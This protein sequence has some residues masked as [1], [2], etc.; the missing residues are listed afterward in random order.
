ML[1]CVPVKTKINFFINAFAARTKTL[2]LKFSSVIWQSPFLLSAEFTKT[3]AG[4]WAIVFAN[5]SRYAIGPLLVCPV[6]PSVLSVC[7]V[8]VLWPNG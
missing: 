4:F 7:N 8:G 1:A 6:C 2:K 5:G 3:A